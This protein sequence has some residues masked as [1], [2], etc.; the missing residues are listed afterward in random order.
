MLG[1]NGSHE[2]QRGAVVVDHLA[3]RKVGQRDQ[4]VVVGMN[5]QHS[6][7]HRTF[8]SISRSPT[9]LMWNMMTTLSK[10]LRFASRPARASPRQPAPRSRP[11]RSTCRNRIRS[12]ARSSTQWQDLKLGLLMHWGT[13][14]QWGIVESWSLCSE[15][16][17]WCTAR[18][19]DD[20]AD[21]QEGVRGAAD[22]VQSGEVRSGALGEGGE[23][24]RH[25]VRRV[26]DEASR[27][28]QHVRHAARP[29]TGSRHRRRRSRPTRAPTS[30]AA[31][32]TRFARRAS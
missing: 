26:H 4:H 20:Y 17:A 19:M 22:D 3:G 11:R 24:R 15:D 28:L 32:S 30:R 12:S 31:S 9:A 6:S 10:Q 18:S 8:C 16:E 1:A 29:T 23:G 14:S 13:Y 27:R 5:Q 25:A 2:V 21:V 7:K